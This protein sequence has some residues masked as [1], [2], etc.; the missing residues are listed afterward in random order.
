M[1]TKPYDQNAVIPFSEPSNP[2]SWKA[3]MNKM[4]PGPNVLHVRGQV[5]VPNPGVEAFLSRKEPQGIVATILLLDLVL[6][7]KPGEWPQ[8]IVTKLATYQEEGSD[9]P[10]KTVEIHAEGQPAVSVPVEIVQ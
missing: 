6:V 1:S 2:D 4:P 10:Y 5:T 8:V 9:L 7:Q 3:T